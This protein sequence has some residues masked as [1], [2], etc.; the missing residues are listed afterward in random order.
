MIR[1]LADTN[2]LGHFARRTHPRLQQ[3]MQHA[4]QTQAIAISVITRAEIQFGLALLAA[5]DKRRK[6]IDRLLD[7][8]PAFP[9]S[10]EVADRYGEV[11]A[12][13]QKTGQT[14]G[15]MDT[16]IAAHALVSDLPVVT[17]NIRH[18]S[19]IPGLRL[20]DWTL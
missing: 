20:E 2:I 12:Q 16:M 1:Y 17:H 5:N 3:R 15:E 13:L 10:A 8:I 4:L 11:A 19:R 9:W 14:I 18:F 6:S 7:E